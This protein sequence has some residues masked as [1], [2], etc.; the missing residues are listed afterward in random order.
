MFEQLTQGIDFASILKTAVTTEVSM[1]D[2]VIGLVG[3]Y[4]TWKAGWFGVRKSIAATKFLTKTAATGV[5]AGTK[6]GGNMLGT[7]IAATIKRYYAGF[8]GLGAL[9]TGVGLGG[10]TESAQYLNGSGEVIGGLIGLG[11]F[12]IAYGIG[13]AAVNTNIDDEKRKRGNYT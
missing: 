4:I 2:L 7:L 1:V 9:A 6:S 13:S 10:L 5:V 11:I 8:M 3:I 12:G